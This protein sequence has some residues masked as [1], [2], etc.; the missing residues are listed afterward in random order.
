MPA[1]RNSNRL[2]QRLTA[3]CIG[4]SLARNISCIRSIYVSSCQP[5]IYNY[6]ICRVPTITQLTLS[7][8]H[9]LDGVVSYMTEFG[10]SAEKFVSTRGVDNSAAHVIVCSYE[11]AADA[12]SLIQTLNGS[13]RIAIEMMIDMMNDDCC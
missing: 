2:R 9:L 12:C 13:G 3:A 8:S 5:A 4:A 11:H 6:V 7:F 1:A 10:G